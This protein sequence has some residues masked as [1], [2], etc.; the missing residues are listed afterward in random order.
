M[1]PHLLETES[2]GNTQAKTPHLPGRV[3]RKRSKKWKELHQ[4]DE[5]FVCEEET[6]GSETEMRGGAF[7][8]L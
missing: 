5:D 1:K 3:T 4:F 6:A 7:Q 2:V 8:Q